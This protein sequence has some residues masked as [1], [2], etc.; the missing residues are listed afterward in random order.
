[1]NIINNSNDTSFNEMG[2][3][4]FSAIPNNGINPLEFMI[5]LN[6]TSFNL[7]DSLARP[8]VTFTMSDKDFFKSYD[9]ELIL[10]NQ[11]STYS[12]LPN[13]LLTKNLYTLASFNSYK[14]KIKRRRKE[15]MLPS[16]ENFIGFSSKLEN[17][18]Y[19]T[20]T[21]ETFPLSN[22]TSE[23]PTLTLL[24]KI[25]IKVQSF[26]VQ[27]E[28]DKRIKTAS[29]TVI[30]SLGLI[31]GAW[32]FAATIYSVLFGKFWIILSCYPTAS[33][34]IA[35]KPWG[36]IQKYGFK[37]NNSVQTKLRNKFEI[38]PLVHH[39]KTTNNSE[40]HEELK[41]RLDSLQLFL[42][43]YVVDVQY[44]EEI[45]KKNINKKA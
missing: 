33:G 21:L 11:L 39:P 12:K 22:G 27:V 24:M 34:A 7:S 43:E 29:I 8:F 19:L 26:I 23:Y 17:L 14:I 42:T 20:S 16:W 45:Y 18:P 37:I 25:E 44:L 15:L 5:Y 35:I 2:D 38:I 41:K 9:Q 6:N 30:T 40:K 36:W 32:G 3:L 31:G 1:M 4:S 13:T 10:T 28:T